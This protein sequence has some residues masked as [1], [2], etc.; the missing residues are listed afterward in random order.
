MLSVLLQVYLIILL[1]DF[2]SGVSHWAE[3]TF[4]DENTPL[5]G[6]TILA[7]NEYHHK[8]PM[9]FLDKSWLESSSVLLVFGALLLLIASLDGEIGWQVI[10]FVAFGVNTNQIHKWSHMRPRKVPW[11]VR[12]LQRCRI[13]QTQ[14]H[15]LK[16]HL[17][18]RNTNFCVVTNHLNYLLDKLGFWRQLEY[19]LVPLLGAP[20]REDLIKAG[21]T[22]SNV[23]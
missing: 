23:S 19:F 4:G 6:K 14:K 17:K 16:H 9:A 20:R 8:Y 1:V 12:Q 22:K 15:H 7:P 13:L 18:P 11:I 10:F 21:L 2:V 5:V 3:D